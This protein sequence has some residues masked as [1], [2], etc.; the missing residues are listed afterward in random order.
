MDKVDE[1]AEMMRNRAWNWS[2]YNFIV[3]KAGNIVSGH[4]RV[5]AAE[6]AGVEIP[7][8][9]IRHLIR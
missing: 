1:Y 5:L 3:D 6:R 4:H 2:E 9:A 7:E 8:R